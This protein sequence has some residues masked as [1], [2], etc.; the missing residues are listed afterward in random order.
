[1]L[2]YVA[3]QPRDLLGELAQLFP[4]RRAPAPRESGKLVQF[5]R[6][7]AGPAVRQFR[8][9]LDLARRQI[10]RLA[11][12]AHRRAQAVGGE[13]ADEPDVLVAVPLVDASDQLFADLAREIE[14][15]VRHR[16]EGLVQEP[17]DEEPGGDRINVREAEQVAHDGGDG[18]AAAATGK[19]ADLRPPRAAPH[20]GGDFAR[21][22][23]Q[24]VIDQ[25]EPAEPVVL[26]EP[27][28]LGEPPLRLAAVQGAGGVALFEPRAAQLSERPRS[29]S[30]LGAVEVGKPISQIPREI[31]PTAPL[32]QGHTISDS[33]WTVTK[34]RFDLLRRAQEELAVRMPHVVR[35]VERRAVPDRHQHIVQAVTRAGVIMHVARRYDAKS[36]GIGDVFQGSSEGE[37]SPDVV[38]LQ[39]DDEVLLPEHRTAPLGQ[40]ARRGSAVPLQHDRQE[41]GPAAGEDDEPS[42]PGFER[43]EVEPGI[44]PVCTAEMSLRNQPAEV[45]VP[46]RRLDEK[47]HMGTVE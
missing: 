3:R 22:V 45:R 28:L 19:Q 4:E 40:A 46:F 33:I 31:E 18:R 41:P 15:D 12:L 21:E 37:V 39:L 2:R 44:A 10:Q 9:L 36:Y 16:G 42:V 38:P 24:I 6:Q 35:A 17:P 32:R 14:V 29:G 23:E 43:G 5:V 30:A 34:Q 1:M 47:R 27:Q 11:D 13:R 25:K 20:V 8:D 26:D 7:S